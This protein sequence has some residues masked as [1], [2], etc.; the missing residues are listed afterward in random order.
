MLLLDST[1][2]N[3]RLA[4]AASPPLEPDHARL[5]AR[6]GLS[7]ILAGAAQGAATCRKARL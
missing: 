7:C 1:I 3:I 4:H 2:T 5:P 6:R